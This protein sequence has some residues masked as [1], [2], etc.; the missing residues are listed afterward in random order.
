MDN[1]QVR[2]LVRKVNGELM[3][4]TSLRTEEKETHLKTAKELTI[5]EV[6]FALEVLYTYQNAYWEISDRMKVR[7]GMLN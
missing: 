3:L 2:N 7:L 1:N 6:Q 5:E 4:N